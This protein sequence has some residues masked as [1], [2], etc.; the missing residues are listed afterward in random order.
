MVYLY[1]YI[2]PSRESLEATPYNQ[3]NISAAKHM[4]IHTKCDKDRK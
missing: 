1:R 4:N 2:I 3:S